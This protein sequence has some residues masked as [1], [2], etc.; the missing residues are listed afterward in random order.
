[1]S[2][3][4]TG[5]VRRIEWLE[6]RQARLERDLQSLADAFGALSLALDE[7]RRLSG[8]ASELVIVKPDGA[9]GM[10][11]YSAAIPDNPGTTGANE[12]VPPRLVPATGTGRVW[13]L[14]D[15]DTGELR[16]REY[17]RRWVPDEEHPDGGTYE[18][19]DAQVWIDNFND[20]EGIPATAKYVVC[21]RHG[22][23]YQALIW[24]CG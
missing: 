5:V 21:R 17:V 9:I 7:A 12:Y 19:E 23:R 15:A 22:G 18:L 10:A 4:L 20:D 11:S 2:F 6:K 14:F 1:M 16:L 8:N 24:H 3:D 13:A